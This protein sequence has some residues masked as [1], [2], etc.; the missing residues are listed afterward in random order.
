MHKD[1]W[2]GNQEA[3]LS[4]VKKD[5]ESFSCGGGKGTGNLAKMVAIPKLFI[6]QDSPFLFEK[7]LLH[8]GPSQA[9]KESQH[10]SL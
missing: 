1:K 3:A 8:S 7:K 10:N 9:P 6:G 4:T 5:E 2:H